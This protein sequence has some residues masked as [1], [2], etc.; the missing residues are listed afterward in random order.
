MPQFWQIGS[1]APALASDL[2]AELERECDHF[3][4]TQHP[5]IVVRQMTETMSLASGPALSQITKAR[6]AYVA[7]MPTTKEQDQ[8]HRQIDAAIEAAVKQAEVMGGLVLAALSGH[9]DSTRPDGIDQRSSINVDQVPMPRQ[10]R[11][12]L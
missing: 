4:A 2:R 5:D 6:D 10:P 12:P 11:E 9:V 1:R 3:L 7:S 8:A